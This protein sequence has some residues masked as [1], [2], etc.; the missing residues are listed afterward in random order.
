MTD[1]LGGVLIHTCNAQIGRL[2]ATCTCT[3]IYQNSTLTLII[4]QYYV[5]VYTCSTP[6]SLVPRLYAF[7]IRATFE[8]L[9]IEKRERAWE[10]LSRE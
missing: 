8:P 10:I 6:C 3:C 9:D 2:F 4:V 5:G 7:I 1:A